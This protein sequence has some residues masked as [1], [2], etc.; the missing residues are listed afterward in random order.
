[1]IQRLA[2]P[3]QTRLKIKEEIVD[4]SGIK[5]DC[6]QDE[7]LFDELTRTED[8]RG[9]GLKA[10]IERQKLVVRQ[11]NAEIKRLQAVVKRHEQAEKK[12]ARQSQARQTR[13]KKARLYFGRNPLA[14]IHETKQNPHTSKNI[15]YPH[16]PGGNVLTPEVVTL[17]CH[18][19][20]GCTG[21]PDF[22]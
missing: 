3:C 2:L 1:M 4:D 22:L 8:T 21:T 18:C 12:W 7:D 5:S 10:R 14:H 19:R 20:A 15:F 13:D 6:Q 16:F 9:G 17:V 11:K